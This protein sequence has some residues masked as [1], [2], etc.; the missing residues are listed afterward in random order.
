MNGRR[1]RPAPRKAGNQRNVTKHETI[2]R[3]G[4]STFVFWYPFPRLWLARV[5]VGAAVACSG[6]QAAPR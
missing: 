1:Q 3:K 5:N 6:M 4:A 2:D